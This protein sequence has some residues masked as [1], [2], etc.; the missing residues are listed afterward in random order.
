[1]KNLINPA[2]AQ[3]AST[4][5]VISVGSVDGILTSAALLR[6]LGKSEEEC[7]LV[8]C[9]AFTVDK[10][11][12]DKWQGKAVT[13]VDLA[14][15]NRDMEMTRAFVARLREKNNQL[16]AVIDEHNSED[17][18]AVLGSFDGLAVEPQ[19]QQGSDDA[20]KSSGELFRRAL[21]AAE[22]EVDT[23]TLELLA[24]ADAGDR[25]DFSTHFGS[26][27]NQ[28]VKSNI[29]DDARRVKI[30]RH[31]AFNSEPD[32]QIATW[33]AEYEEILRNHDI[34]V[35]QK[36]DRGDGIHR[37]NACDMQ[38]D[39]TTLMFR[40]YSEGARVVALYGE[41]FVPA[42]KRKRTVL[43]FGTNDKGLDLMAIVRG[44]GVNPLG[45]F[46]QKVNVELGD[47]EKAMAAIREA[48][49]PYFVRVGI[50]E[51]LDAGGRS[52]GEFN[53]LL[54]FGPGGGY[55][56]HLQ[57]Q[58][59]SHLGSDPKWEMRAGLALLAAFRRSDGAEEGLH[60]VQ[61][62][63]EAADCCFREETWTHG[64]GAEAPFYLVIE[65]KKVETGW[66]RPTLAGV[67]TPGH[68]VAPA[69][70]PCTCGSGFS[71]WECGETT[72][73]CG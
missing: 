36:V 26:I 14:V 63:Q 38:V 58:N 33:I 40:L 30:A 52:L 62:P 13:L 27:A 3:I 16:V 66:L 71:Y 10:L 4:D 7:D 49:R 54:V 44:A 51:I 41:A 5:L 11:P 60:V 28:A 12:V 20:P 68:P 70:R 8:F 50:Q 22:V 56:L 1:M 53:G 55:P 39:M 42:E 21:V 35:D 29:R 72:P 67:Y 19:S 64:Q 48:T 23:H 57:A 47:E 69:L 46:A 43:S 24:A 31:L 37:V 25:M 17:W 73:E 2:I 59:I 32:E 45:G 6:L 9:Q 15:N 65:Q 18:L 61:T 34:I